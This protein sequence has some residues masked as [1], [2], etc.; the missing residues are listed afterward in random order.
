MTPPAGAPPPARL[1]RPA[2]ISP[3][4]LTCTESAGRAAPDERASERAGTLQTI[5][6]TRAPRPIPGHCPRRLVSR[7]SS[8]PAPPAPPPHWSGMFH[9]HRGSHRL[10]ATMLRRTM[11]TA[12]QRQQPAKLHITFTS[13]A[14][15]RTQTQQAV[16]TLSAIFGVAAAPA[17]ALTSAGGSA[18]STAGQSRALTTQTTARRPAPGQSI[19]MM[20]AN[21]GQEPK[22]QQERQ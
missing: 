22:A 6:S 15:M 1:L 5:D 10:L 11:H 20:M 12:A 9:S 4:H 3:S 21:T 8:A 13:A 16:L 18:A 7:S 17:T 2:S 19:A 14:Q